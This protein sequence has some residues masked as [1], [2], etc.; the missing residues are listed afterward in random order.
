MSSIQ[1]EV[2]EAQM[3]TRKGL[4]FHQPRL[5]G[6]PLG[7]QYEEPAAG[8]DPDP[9]PSVGQDAINLRHLPLLSGQRVLVDADQC[10]CGATDPN[11]VGFGKRHR[12]R[13]LHAGRIP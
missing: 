2:A 1:A 11:A 3:W 10:A 7:I 12:A 9:M 5:R 4:V 13:S 6:P 8:S